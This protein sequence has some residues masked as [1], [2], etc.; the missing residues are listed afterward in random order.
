MSAPTRVSPPPALPV[1]A[2]WLIA[3]APRRDR[4]DDVPSDLAEL[5]DDRC[6]RYGRL[7]A[8]RRL[9]SDVLSLWRGAFRGG[10]MRQDLRYALRLFRKQPGPVVIALAGLAVAIAVVTTMFTVV[11]ATMLKP[12]GMDDPDAVVSV[13]DAAHG[14]RPFPWW[15]YRMFLHM[16]ANATLSTVEASMLEKVRLSATA[17]E[18]AGTARWLLFVSGGYLETL[19]GRPFLGRL[20]VPA[21]DEP[22][23][24]PAVVVS[25]QLWSTRLNGDPGIVGETVWVGGTPVTLVGVLQPGFSGP[26]SI[27]PSIWGA[28]SAADEIRGGSAFSPT[29]GGLVDV[30]ARLAPGATRDAA[31]ENLAAVVASAERPT[32][33]HD[34]RPKVV[35]LFSAASPID[36]PEA[37]ESY[38]ALGALFAVV[39]LVLVLACANTANLLLAAASARARE[40]GVRLALGATR[41]RLVRQLLSESVL[42]AAG[43]GLSGYVLA[44]ALGP[45]VSS[46]I[47]VS[48]EIDVAPDA[49]VLI[50]TSVV[51]LS[52][53]LGAGL[54][55]ARFGARGDV[56]SAL[57]S[58]TGPRT[59]R[60]RS[61]RVRTSFAGFQASIAMLLLVGALLLTRTAIATARADVGYDANRLVAVSLGGNRTTANDPVFLQRAVEALHDLPAVEH[62]S[63]TQRI[64]F[65][66]S[67]ESDRITHDGRSLTV[68]VQRV[69]AAFFRTAGVRVLRGRVFTE[70]EVAA[71]APVAVIGEQVAGRFF[72]GADPIG[73]SLSNVPGEDG[74]R[75]PPAAIIGVVSDA[76]MSHLHT[77]GFGTIYHPIGRERSNPPGL[78]VRSAVPGLVIGQVE[79]ALRRLDA[80]VRPTVS[81]VSEGLDVFLASKQVLAWMAGPLALLAFVLATLGVFGVTA[82][83][84]RQRAHEVSVRLAI[85]ATA[86]DVLRQLVSDSLRP[87]AIGLVVGL[88]AALGVSRVFASLLAGI[89]PHDPLSVGLAIAMLLTGALVAVVVPARRAAKID[90]AGIL[91]ES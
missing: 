69:D 36:G 84:V 58:E 53:G 2:R 45:V 25:H 23:A 30:I 35:R 26:G 19:G 3:V 40:I 59:S 83:V 5:F 27:R 22:G 28:F 68:Y 62:V 34:S 75:Q 91:K 21:D 86:G 85:G 15:P 71:Q 6:V 52:C 18:D 16:R 33:G 82:F 49:R 80:Q 67:V 72:P 87:V 39:G 11:N 88:V 13:T 76:L 47:L 14:S 1:W 70:E 61:S 66:G 51:A 77:Q 32:E 89:S 54:S 74:R 55:P 7:Y 37:A 31:E 50:F 44:L 48:P 4:G 60:R 56:L 63:I 12:F 65:G 38:L 29:Y 73:Q 64:P 90:P 24:P 9:G 41:R 8:H 43:A 78:V 79:Q 46:V 10:T 42:L 57:R 81:L 17:G 20:L